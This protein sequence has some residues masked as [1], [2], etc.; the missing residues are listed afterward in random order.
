MELETKALSFCRAIVRG[1]ALITPTENQSS[2]LLWDLKGRAKIMQIDSPEEKKEE[3][4]SKFGMV[5]SVCALDDDSI[6]IAFEGGAG[7]VFDTKR[8]KFRAVA[9]VSK[10]PRESLS[11]WFCCETTG[12]S[13]LCVCNNVSDMRLH[14]Q[15][16]RW[17][18]LAGLRLLQ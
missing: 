2:L 9:T 10:D 11:L 14:G 17:S 13:G 5:M 6:F 16:A 7:C 15:T 8:A 4:A 1:D 18:V 3:S 12:S